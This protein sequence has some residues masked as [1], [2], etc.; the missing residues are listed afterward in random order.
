[1]TRHRDI[2]DASPESSPLR[3]TVSAASR[4]EPART[5]RS[6][7]FVV[8]SDM[9]A[10]AFL[11]DHLRALSATFDVSL[12]ANTGDLAL[13][14]AAGIPGKVLPAPI[15]RQISLWQDLRA[16]AALVRIFRAGRFAAVQSVTP[17][18]GLLAMCAAAIV[19]VPLRTHIFTGQVWATRKGPMRI[20]LKNLDRLTARLATVVLADSHSQREFLISE[21]VVA[22]AR[23]SVLGQGSICGVDLKRFR[24]DPEARVMVRQSLTIPL[25]SPV[26]LFLGRLN[27]D[28]GVLD[29]ALAFAQHAS[30]ATGSHLMLVGSDEEELE[31]TIRS[32]CGSSAGRLRFVGLTSTPERYLAAADVLV[33]PSYREGFGSVVIEAAATGIPALV[34]RIYGLTDAVVPEATGLLHSPGDWNAIAAGMDLLARDRPLRERLGRQART[35]AE[36]E[37][38]KER[39]VDDLVRFYERRTTAP[40][41]ARWPGS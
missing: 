20:L 26:F 3:A 27:R 36:L 30:R 6:I 40:H 1:M 10:K 22:A 32:A 13:L 12:V 24:P 23:I 18:A 11:L 2:G 34:S 5:L 35:R 14:K 25:E 9:T 33:L 4:G 29:L 38:A 31:A 15:A 17:K 37:F 16:L 41:T 39:V 8:A 19:R 28:K 7:C 21:R